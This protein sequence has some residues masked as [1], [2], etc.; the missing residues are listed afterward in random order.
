MSLDKPTT[1]AGLFGWPV[2]AQ[3]RRPLPGPHVELE[4]A[5]PHHTFGLR[6]SI[7]RP[8]AHRDS[9]LSFGRG[10][11]WSEHAENIKSLCVDLRSHGASCGHPRWL[12]M[13]GVTAM[14]SEGT[15]TEY[16]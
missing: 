6:F 1:R 14:K 3:A 9:P 16:G 12:E 7:R 8:V 11:S 2:K 13:L 4:M 15:G 5:T 10:K